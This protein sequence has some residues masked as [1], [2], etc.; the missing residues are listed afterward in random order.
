MSHRSVLVEGWSPGIVWAESNGLLEGAQ[1]VL[2][3]SRVCECIRKHAVCDGIVRIELERRLAGNQGECVLL[4][5]KPHSGGGQVAE[6]FLIVQSHRSLHQA[7]RLVQRCLRGLRL[8]VHHLEH[9]AIRQTRMC[10]CELIVELDRTSKQFLGFPVTL[11]RECVYLRHAEVIA[12]PGPEIPRGLSLG[13]LTFGRA[14]LGLDA[15]GNGAG[16]LILEGE[17]IV[18]VAVVALSPDVVT[19]G[20]LEQLRRDTHSVTRSAHTALQHVS[21]SEILSQPAHIDRLTFEYESRISSNDGQPAILRE[22]GNDVFRDPVGKVLVVGRT[23]HVVERQDGDLR[24]TFR[25]RGRGSVGGGILRVHRVGTHW[26]GDVLDGLLA[27]ELVVQRQHSADGRAHRL[28][29]ADAAGLGQRFESRGN[30][31]SV[32]VDLALVLNHLTD[33]HAHAKQH[34]ALFRKRLVL[35]PQLLL[36]SAGTTDRIRDGPEFSQDR[37]A[38]KVHHSAI[39]QLDGCAD[40]VET[41]P[42]L[43]VGGILILSG[44]TRVAHRVGVEDC[45]KLALFSLC[46]MWLT[47][48]RHGSD[49]SNQPITDLRNGFDDLWISSIIPE[50]LADLGDGVAERIV[51]DHHTRPDGIL[52][53]PAGDDL[54]RLF[55]KTQ[56][57]RHR[58]WLQADGLATL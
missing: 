19:R 23:A 6:G 53:L 55:G 48:R 38:G 42:Q 2:E 37:I 57:K 9:H 28:G 18:E 54:A 3:A 1:R 15:S 56:E 12:V 14:E 40:Q 24:S 17:D 7:E 41:G 46:C 29:D 45:R 25:R 51:A 10:K 13:T 11:F 5:R 36:K 22:R 34:S 26:T 4:S 47:V 39:V 58:A 16:N 50:R 20:C 31:H 32:A 21:D 30:V 35:G 27:Q 44:Q 8:V 52:E 33:V 43:L 49:C